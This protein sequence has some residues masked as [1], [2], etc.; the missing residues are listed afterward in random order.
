MINIVT[1]DF[2]IIMHECI[3]FYN[4]MIEEDDG[5]DANLFPFVNSFPADLNLYEYL[6]RYI[7]SLK[8][9]SN[10]YFIS[11]HQNIAGY[12]NDLPED[13]EYCLYNI[14]HHHDVGYDI[15]W[16]I[17]SLFA[18]IGDW[19]KYA[20]EKKLIHKYVWINDDNSVPVEKSGE[21]FIDEIF[22]IRDFNLMELSDKTDML[23]LCG[24]PEWIPPIYQP[25]FSTWQTLLEET[26]HKDYLVDDF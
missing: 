22:N 26:E 13:E 11:T 10:I 6:T 23:V 15:N 2:D 7:F 5:L 4:D 12:L 25:L 3:Q 24:S 9:K 16:R 14:D 18:G 8:D 17:P 19:V 1:I 21:K 20:R